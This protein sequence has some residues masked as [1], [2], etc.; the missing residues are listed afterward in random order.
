MYA[1]YR[2]K[3]FLVLLI[4]AIAVT[5]TISFFD[6]MR[7]KEEIV[8]DNQVE[9]KHASE[10]SIN[11]L[12]TI[13]KVYE[14]LNPKIAENMEESTEWLLNLYDQNPN[15]STW[16]FQ[17]LAE[18]IEMDIYIID[19]KN[20]IQFSNVQSEIGMD[21]SECCKTLSEQLHARRN[22]G[23]L[24]IDKID[25]DQKN[26]QIKKFSY[27]AT[28]D[29]QYLIELGYNLEN[30]EVFQQFNFID[31]IDAI[32]EESSF[33]KAIHIL[34]FGGNAYGK[35]TNSETPQNR[36]ES[37]EKVRESLNPLETEDTYAGTDVRVKYIPFVSPYDDSATTF[38]VVEII[39]DN[40]Y[41]NPYFATNYQEFII[42]LTIIARSE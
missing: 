4:F 18:E 14:L 31:E 5:A 29:R 3:L 8:T 27:K 1:N 28:R 11:A 26:E 32:V 6:Y 9:I 35:N 15:F 25:I 30:E 21:F 16:D 34:N 7:L 2:L 36:R 39:Y 22:S 42:Q 41:V 37:F 40:E 19:D 24:F 23:K 20:V 33:I 13:E 10:E 12:Y 38:K 17:S